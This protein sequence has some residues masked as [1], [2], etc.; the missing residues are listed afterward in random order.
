MDSCL[1]SRK[2][3][4]GIILAAIKVDAFL[5]V[6]ANSTLTDQ[7][8]DILQQKYAIKRLGYRT[9]FLGWSLSYNEDGAI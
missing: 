1:V 8:H 3:D 6:T 9:E 4:E 5:V 7:F 2:R